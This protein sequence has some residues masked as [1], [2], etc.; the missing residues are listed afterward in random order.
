MY[1]DLYYTTQKETNKM[2]PTNPNLISATRTWKNCCASTWLI[3]LP[4]HCWAH[5]RRNVAQGGHR[6]QAD[7][8]AIISPSAPTTSTAARRSL[9]LWLRARRDARIHELVR[10][11][12]LSAR[13]LSVLFISTRRSPASVAKAASSRRG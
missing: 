11:K 13:G 1:I 7:H 2:K 12:G 6:H 4:T 5:A 8:A 3:S 9:S 10:Q